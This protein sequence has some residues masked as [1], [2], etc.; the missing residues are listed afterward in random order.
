M[1][2]R[3]KVNASS[4]K[5]TPL[6]HGQR[7]L[8]AP[9]IAPVGPK[10]SFCHGA[11]ERRPR[12]PAIAAR[13]K[14]RGHF[15]LLLVDGWHT[16]LPRPQSAG[17]FI[18]SAVCAAGAWVNGAAC[19]RYDTVEG[20]AGSMQRDELVTYM[21]DHEGVATSELARVTSTAVRARCG[22]TFVVQTMPWQVW[23]ASVSAAVAMATCSKRSTPM[24]SMRGC[25]GPTRLPLVQRRKRPSRARPTFS[26]TCSCA[27]TG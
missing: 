21:R 20:G 10:A 14:G 16:K 2:L 24:H 5:S 9:A 13:N 3:C 18:L 8:W 6:L 11:L 12:Q 4:A 7:W 25:S 22:T 1:G 17:S 19:L 23:R 26:T 15:A 27:M